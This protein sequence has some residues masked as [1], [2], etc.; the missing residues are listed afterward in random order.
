MKKLPFILIV[1]LTIFALTASSKPVGE[2]IKEANELEYAGKLDEAAALMEQAATEHPDNSDIYANWGM[3][4]GQMAGQ[5]EDMMEAGALSTKSFELLNKAVELD[6]KN[7]NPW[8]FRGIMGVNVPKFLGKLQGAIDD[9]KQV[10]KL[11]QE[12][13]D[14]FPM[15]TLLTSYKFLAIAYEKNDDLENALAVW[16]K[17]D[18]TGLDTDTGQEAREK[19]KELESKGIKETVPLKEAPLDNQQKTEKLIFPNQSSF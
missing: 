10:E 2:Y 18:Q 1:V 7:P 4:V 19:I 14:G 13:P 8:L 9:F 3:F 5:T 12:N 15:G 6:P 17:I 16:K 11:F